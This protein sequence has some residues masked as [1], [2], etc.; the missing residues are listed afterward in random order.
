[1]DR[2]LT[3]YISAMRSIVSALLLVALIVASASLA[4]IQFTEVEWADSTESFVIDDEGNTGAGSD[5]VVS[6]PQSDVDVVSRTTT[7]C[8]FR[9]IVPKYVL[10][11]CL[12]LDC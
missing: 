8:D 10:Y 4:P 3:H 1:M 11:R 2:L 12:R 6:I 9:D 5:F 7:S